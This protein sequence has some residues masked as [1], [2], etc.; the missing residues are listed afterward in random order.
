MQSQCRRGQALTRHQKHIGPKSLRRSD[1]E[2]GCG[3]RSVSRRSDAG[4]EFVGWRLRDWKDGSEGYGSA[5]YGESGKSIVQPGGTG[6]AGGT[7][8]ETPAL[9][10]SKKHAEEVYFFGGNASKRGFRRKLACRT[11]RKSF[12]HSS[13]R[14]SWVRS[15]PAAHFARRIHSPRC[16][17]CPIRKRRCPR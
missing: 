11:T 9:G 6:P 16:R 13:Y 1:A 7:P 3:R 15:F 14:F 12:V 17:R 5:A 8:G 2:S 4:V 10:R